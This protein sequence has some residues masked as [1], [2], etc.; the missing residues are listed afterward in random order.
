MNNYRNDTLTGKDRLVNHK[1]GNWN[2][3][4][5]INL[6]NLNEVFP[7]TSISK[8]PTNVEEFKYFTQQKLHGLFAVN[9][10]FI[11]PLP[12]KSFSFNSF[13]HLFFFLVV[14]LPPFYILLLFCAPAF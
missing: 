8:F 7:A 3:R 12:N 6:S 2:N 4:E 1:F 10:F 9:P 14:P 5:G 11:Y 13:P